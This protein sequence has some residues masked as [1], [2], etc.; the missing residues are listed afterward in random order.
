MTSLL[1]IGA[2]RILGTSYGSKKESGMDNRDIMLAE[3][4]LEVYTAGN[5]VYLWN[6]EI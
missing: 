3:G 2:D 1:S 4:F 5:R 6:K